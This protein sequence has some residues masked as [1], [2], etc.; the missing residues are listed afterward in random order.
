MHQ[1]SG[2]TTPLTLKQHSCKDL[3]QTV[4]AR[5]PKEAQAN[6][7]WQLQ[8]RIYELANAS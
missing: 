3:E 2:Q 6:K 4:F 7:I 1:E 8:K 5:P